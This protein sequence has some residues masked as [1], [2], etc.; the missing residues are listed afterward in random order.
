MKKRPG[1]TDFELVLEYWLHLDLPCSTI[2]G[3]ERCS[4][5]PVLEG[6]AR[7][8]LPSIADPFLRSF[9]EEKIRGCF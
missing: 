5:R 7:E 6:L 3:R 8:S 1:L 9:L 2:V 4:N